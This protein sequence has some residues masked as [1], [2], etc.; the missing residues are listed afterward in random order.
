M[1]HQSIDRLSLVLAT[2]IHIKIVG[3]IVILCLD[4]HHN[5]VGEVFFGHWTDP[6]LNA[7]VQQLR[8]QFSQFLIDLKGLLLF[9]GNG[10]DP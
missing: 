10:F 7:L 5:L 2:H 9:L 4:R 1:S 3:L 8:N 6:E